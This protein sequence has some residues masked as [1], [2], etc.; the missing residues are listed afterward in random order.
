MK[1][2]HY[3]FYLFGSKSVWMAFFNRSL[4][5]CIW[6]YTLYF[7]DLYPK[8]ITLPYI[9]QHNIRERQS[10]MW[11]WFCRDNRSETKYTPSVCALSS[12]KTSPSYLCPSSSRKRCISVISCLYLILYLIVWW[13]YR[14]FA[15]SSGI[16]VQ[17]CLFL[18]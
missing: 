1:Q 5:I 9:F 13:N 10:R 18:S 7:T 8:M 14:K 16:V 11:H 15:G 17:Y 4:Q 2:S 3:S 12:I 6:F